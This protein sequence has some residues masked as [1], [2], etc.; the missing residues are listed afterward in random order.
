MS[1]REVVLG[2][3]AFFDE[4]V[5]VIDVEL[6]FVQNKVD[7]LV[8]DEAPPRLASQQPLFQGRPLF[9]AEAG[10]VV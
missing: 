4:R 8:T 5:D 6:P 3:Q 1:Q 2:I 10:Q 7:Q 9:V